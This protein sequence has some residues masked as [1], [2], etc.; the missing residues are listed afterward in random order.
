M[1][2]RVRY[3]TIS[4]LAIEMTTQ[5][6]AEDCS[7]FN[8]I[9]FSC[10]QQ[11]ERGEDLIIPET[12]SPFLNMAL[13]EA[14]GELETGYM[15]YIQKINARKKGS[16]PESESAIDQRSTADQP[17]TDNRRE[18]KREEKKRSEERR[19]RSEGMQGGRPFSD[20]EQQSLN[21]AL[22]HAFL[23]PDPQFWSLAE[24]VGYRITLD[25]IRKAAELRSR[26]I[27]YVVKLMTEAAAE[28]GIS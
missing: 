6:S 25:S 18:E 8:K 12:D 14:A 15:N 21:S 4:R 16:D 26:S 11:L 5:L 10:F 2:S 7:Q 28:G 9:I 27:P 17:P 3:L 13:R 22:N 20:L 1:K 24:K 19:E 23:S